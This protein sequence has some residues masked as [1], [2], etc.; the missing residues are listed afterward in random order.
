MSSDRSLKTTWPAALLVSGVVPVLSGFG[1]LAMP[2]ATPDT[3]LPYLSAT[4]TVTGFRSVP[5]LVLLGW[6]R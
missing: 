6:L 5:G 1:P 2:M 3:A 4:C